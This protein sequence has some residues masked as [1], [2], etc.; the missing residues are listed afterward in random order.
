M[1]IVLSIVVVLFLLNS[2]KTIEWVADTYA[3]QYGFAYKKI[4]G[5]LLTGLEVEE[6][7]FKN[8]TLLDTLKLGSNTRKDEP[9]PSSD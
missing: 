3:P 2:T 8:A 5:G 9:W 7:T 1:L 4:S 6:L